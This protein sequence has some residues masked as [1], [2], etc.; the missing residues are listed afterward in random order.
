MIRDYFKIAFIFILVFT[1]SL[2][3]FDNSRK[4]E[5]DVKRNEDI[6][7]IAKAVEAYKIA[8][9]YYPD[10]SDGKI[11]ACSGP[12][13]KVLKDKNGI[14]VREKGALRDKLVGLVP[15][16][17]GKDS[18]GDASDGNYPAF[19]EKLPQDPLSQKGFSYRYDLEDGQYFVYVSYET[20]K[21][22][23]FSKN[24]SRQKIS[25]GLKFCNAG[26]T[27]GVELVK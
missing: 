2:W 20:Q 9:G 7:N 6:S 15:C 10:S 17:W 23:D 13:T 12:Q 24:I 26:R 1:A 5:R 3:S 25:C 18:L 19:L 27:N 4:R 14:P 22:P 16:E 21:M 8:F 11:V